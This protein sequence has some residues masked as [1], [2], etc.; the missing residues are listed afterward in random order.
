[1]TETTILARCENGHEQ[2]FKITHEDDRDAQEM[3]LY[4]AHFIELS[5]Y[6]ANES[7]VGPQGCLVCGAKVTMKVEQGGNR[8]KA[9]ADA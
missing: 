2:R 9:L 1:M 7:P 3:E 4:W 5:E 8:E 6:S